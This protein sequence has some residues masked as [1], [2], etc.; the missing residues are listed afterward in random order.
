MSLCNKT[1]KAKNLL[2]AGKF[3]EALSIIKAFR[4][5]FTKEEKRS[6]EIAYESLSGNEQFYKSIGIDTDKEIE[7][8]SLLLTHKY[9]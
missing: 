6:I 5:G 1:E 3:K 7:K 9:L 4:I 2:K 8:V